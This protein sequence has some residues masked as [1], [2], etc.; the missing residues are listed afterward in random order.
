MT[1]Y[2]IFLCS[3]VKK[4]VIGALAGCTFA[5]AYATLALSLALANRRR[6]TEAVNRQQT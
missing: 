6:Q 1:Q 4:Q 3:E 5:A 2:A